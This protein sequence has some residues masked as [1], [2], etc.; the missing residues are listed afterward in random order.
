MERGSRSESP[1]K[2][3]IQPLDLN[4]QNNRIIIEG[5]RPVEV[6]E[7]KAL[8]PENIHSS[9]KRSNDP[10]HSSENVIPHLALKVFSTFQSNHPFLLKY[11]VPIL[12][13]AFNDRIFQKKYCK[14]NIN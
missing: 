10:K 3:A 11:S 14:F 1:S 2:I 4:L 12:N 9:K 7:E 6:E 5:K 13:L 8:P